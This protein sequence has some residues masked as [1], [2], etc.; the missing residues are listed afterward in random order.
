MLIAPLAHA[1]DPIY[2]SGSSQGA[3]G[4]DVVSYFTQDA[5]VQ[6]NA[7]YKVEW[8]GAQWLFSSAGNRDKFKANPAKY[9]PQ[10]GGYCAWAVSQNYTAR[11]SPRHWSVVDGKLY[12][13]Y[14]GAVKLNWQRNA[15]NNIV[16]GNQNWPGLLGNG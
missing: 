8:Q 6:G 16:R 1:L 5:A 15:R 10:Y 13:N 11:G 4:Y 9:A 3:G 14:N 2:K 7:D 12:L